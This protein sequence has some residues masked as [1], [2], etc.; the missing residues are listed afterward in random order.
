M[1]NYPHIPV[2]LNEVITALK[3]Q[4][5][6]WYLDATLGDGGHTIAMLKKKAKVIAFDQDENAISRATKNI[7]AACPGVKLKLF[8]N[9][10]VDLAAV[11]CLL[12]NQNF[13]TFSDVLDHFPGLKLSGALFDL[14]VST[15]QILS[16]DRGFSFQSEAPLDMRMDKR[17][18]VTAADLI[19][20]LPEKELSRL[21]LEYGG[22][23]Y[24]AKIARHLVSSRLI[25]PITTTTQLAEIIARLKPHSKTNPATQVFQALR[26]AVNLE[27]ESIIEALPEVALRLTPGSTL[28]I[29]S[30]HSGEDRI[31][32]HFIRNEETLSEVN[33]K[34]ILPGEEEISRNPRGRSA[35]LRLATKNDQ[36]HK[37]SQ[38]TP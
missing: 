34:P 26:I 5:G 7:Q 11:D 33:K 35:K 25:K 8:A 36:N 27:R 13:S 38:S 9:Q 10:P 12:V 2:L 6:K 19:N 21:F 14:G 29:I 28:A 20:A 1:T 4:A 16:P 24:A 32:K 17:L 31:A 3:P 22:E 37:K 15:Y 30:F 18:G 23:P